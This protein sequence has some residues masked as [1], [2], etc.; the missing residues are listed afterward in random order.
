M[1]LKN[2]VIKNIGPIEEL[3]VELPFKENGDPKPVI[4]VGENGSGKTILQSQIIDV[5]HEMGSS[6]FEDIGV[7]AGLV[8]KY[9]KISGGGNLQ[10]GKNYGFSLLKFSD[11][12]NQYLEYFDK[13]GE[14][15][16]ENFTNYITDFLNGK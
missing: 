10:V 6:L 13:I 8:R 9:Y 2:I 1:Y 12:E 7:Q 4:F 5:F 3:F 16:K 14:V 15:K 11:N